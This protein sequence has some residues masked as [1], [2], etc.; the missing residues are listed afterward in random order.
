MASDQAQRSKTRSGENPLVNFEKLRK[1][2]RETNCEQICKSFANKNR[3]AQV[4]PFPKGG[5][6]RE[7]KCNFPIFFGKLECKYSR[8][9][10][11]GVPLIYAM[12][13]A[14]L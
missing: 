11:G 1:E 4:L 5:F 8:I 7:C 9:E 2:T 3:V 13:K 6:R 12:P 10:I 14:E